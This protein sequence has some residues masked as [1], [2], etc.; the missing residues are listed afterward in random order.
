MPAGHTALPG[1]GHRVSAPVSTTPGSSLSHNQP[2]PRTEASAVRSIGC[3]QSRTRPSK[4]IPLVVV[5]TGRDVDHLGDNL[6]AIDTS[7]TRALPAMVQPVPPGI[8]PPC[9]IHAEIGFHR[10]AGSHQALRGILRIDGTGR[11][12]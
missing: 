12:P 6:S 11:S 9:D 4:V 10:E 7:L 3:P 8:R 2:G 5:T 1:N